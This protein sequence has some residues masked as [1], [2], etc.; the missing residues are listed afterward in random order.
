MQVTLTKHEPVVQQ[1]AE[2]R[3][4]LWYMEV[5]AEVAPD[6]SNSGSALFVYQIQP[7]QGLGDRFC[8][9]ASAAQMRDT[10]EGR[11]KAGESAFYRTSNAQ[12][13]CRSA[14]EMDDVWRAVQSDVRLLVRD[15]EKLV[16]GAQVSSVVTIT[17]SDLI[18]GTVPAP[19]IPRAATM[20]F[21]ADN[22]AV[23]FYNTAGELVGELPIALPS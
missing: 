8:A 17:A 23:Q 15:W 4:A 5:T 16:G 14:A 12:F 3:T 2:R 21:N 11:D 1:D 20:R 10:P 6:S 7:L 18:T 9:V 13:L 19:T 22:S